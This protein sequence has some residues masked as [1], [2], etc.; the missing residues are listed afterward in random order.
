MLNAITIADPARHHM[1]VMDTQPK[2]NAMACK[3]YENE[4][5][6]ANIRFQ[7]VGIENINVMRF[8]LQKLLEVSCTKALSTVSCLVWRTLAGCHIKAVLDAVTFLAKAIAVENATVLV[9]CS[10]GW[11]R[12]S[13]VCSLGSLSL[14]L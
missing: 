11:D 4:G 6:Y 10:D 2:L 9:H 3:G 12:T 1:Y 14:D 8:S 7:F 13:Q 5:N